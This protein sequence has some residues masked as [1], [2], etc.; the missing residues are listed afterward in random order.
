MAIDKENL[1]VSFQAKF[2][3]EKLK[4]LTL[5]EYTDIQQPGKIEMI[6]PIGLKQR[7]TK[8]EGYLFIP[9]IMEFTNLK[10]ILKKKKDLGMMK[11]TS[12]M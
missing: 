9:G 10:T 4:T 6:L 2:P 1:Y 3:L 8:L 5:E 12:G 7:L 11:I